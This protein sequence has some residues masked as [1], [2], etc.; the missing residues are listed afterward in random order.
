MAGTGVV[1]DRATAFDEEQAD[2]GDLHIDPGH[3]LMEYFLKS[4]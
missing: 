2:N 4:G 3:E 1:A